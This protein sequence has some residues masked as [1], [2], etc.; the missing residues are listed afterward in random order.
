M[1]R[2]FYDR[3]WWPWSIGGTLVIIIAV[4]YSVQLD[5]QINEW[6]GRFY[7]ALQKALATPGALTIEEFN[8]YLYE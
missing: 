7:D 4:W 2:F 1:F 8:E 6:F 3:K 5:V